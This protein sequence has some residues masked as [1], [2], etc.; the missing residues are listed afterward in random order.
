VAFSQRSLDKRSEGPG[1]VSDDAKFL[2]LPLY[3]GKQGAIVAVRFRLRFHPD[4][5]HAGHIVF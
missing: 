5:H 1:I 3:I 2:D 4:P